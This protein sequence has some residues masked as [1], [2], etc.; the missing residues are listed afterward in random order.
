MPT[1]RCELHGPDGKFRVGN[2][3]GPGRPPAKPIKQEGEGSDGGEVDLL[4][5]FNAYLKQYGPE[6]F[7]KELLRKSPVTFAQTLNSLAKLQAAGGSLSKDER[8]NVLAPEGLPFPPGFEEAELLDEI[9]QLKDQLADALRDDPKKP[10]PEPSLVD[11]IA[12]GPILD[13]PMPDVAGDA[14]GPGFDD[15]DGPGSGGAVSLLVGDSERG[16]V[17]C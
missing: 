7:C 6:R 14:D 2:K 3:G 12:T 16:W 8:I 4:A 9:T 17:D 5:A 11:D 1:D 15:G 10:E 13:A